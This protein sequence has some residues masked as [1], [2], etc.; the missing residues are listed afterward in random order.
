MLVSSA[1]IKLTTYFWQFLAHM[2][3]PMSVTPFALFIKHDCRLANQQ[4]ASDTH[5]QMA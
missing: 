4:M 3:D 2:P 5:M 1:Y